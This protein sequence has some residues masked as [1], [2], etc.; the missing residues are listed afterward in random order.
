MKGYL[1][2][3]RE[4]GKLSLGPVPLP[5]FFRRHVEASRAA[6]A[7]ARFVAMLGSGITE[8]EMRSLITEA[9]PITSTIGGLMGKATFAAGRTKGDTISSDRG[10]ILYALVRAMKPEKVVETGV[11]SGSSSRYMLE[12]MRRNG[13]GHLYS[14]DLPDGT[15][16][17]E[18]KE[19]GWLVPETLRD[20]WTLRLGDARQELPALLNEIGDI[21]LFFHDSL[22]TTDHMLFE[23][24]CA[25]PRLKPRGIL[26]SDD[27][28]FNEAWERFTGPKDLRS[29]LVGGM[30]FT[31]KANK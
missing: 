15:G 13:R 20:L 8:G 1:V 28:Y 12:A 25:Y 5:F 4:N 3:L 9:E 2:R 16:I 24:G 11:A 10:P 18:G 23:Y 26:G 22:H 6:K 19:V 17:A 31:M 7:P 14:I 27:V 21:D 29:V 30:G